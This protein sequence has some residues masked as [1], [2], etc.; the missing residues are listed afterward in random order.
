MTKKELET[1]ILTELTSSEMA[2]INPNIYWNE[3]Y[4]DYYTDYVCGNYAKCWD[5]LMNNRDLLTI[6]H[7]PEEWK[8]IAEKFIKG[9]KIV[10]KK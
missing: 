5:F 7:T 8:S 2:L 1:K 9:A 3:K 4:I 6:E 10:H